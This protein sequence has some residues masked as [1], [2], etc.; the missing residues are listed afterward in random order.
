[1]KFDKGTPSQSGASRG[2]FGFH[3][4]G[5]LQRKSNKGNNQTARKFRA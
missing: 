5:R 4:G 3:V 1:M 2:D